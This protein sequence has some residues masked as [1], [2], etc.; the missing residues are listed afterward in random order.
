MGI[1]DQEGITAP[2]SSSRIST[3]VKMKTNAFNGDF[4]ASPTSTR[5][6]AQIR[7][8]SKD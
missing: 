4:C 5:R 3:I 2:F 1:D 7:I 8:S 6:T